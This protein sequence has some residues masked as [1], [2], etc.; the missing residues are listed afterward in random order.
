MIL[1]FGTATRATAAEPPVV[2]IPGLI[3][4]MYLEKQ[5]DIRRYCEA[6]KAL[7]GASLDATSSRMLLRQ[8]AKE[9]LP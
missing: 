2:Y 7:R 4:D 8:V 1:N 9:F 5:Q 6:Y 3:G